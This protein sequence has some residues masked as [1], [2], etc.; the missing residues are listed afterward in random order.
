[1]VPVVE[2]GTLIGVVTH[3]DLHDLVAGAGPDGGV[4]RR[5]A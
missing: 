5:A 1:V 3:R 4:A 2:G